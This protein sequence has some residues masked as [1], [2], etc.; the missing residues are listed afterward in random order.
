MEVLWN[1][2]AGFVRTVDKL[3]KSVLFL[4]NYFAWY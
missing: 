4:V 1:L 3:P 2:L